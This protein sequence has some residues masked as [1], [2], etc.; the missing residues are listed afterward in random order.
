MAKIR[1]HKTPTEL[2]L[3]LTADITHIYVQTKTVDHMKLCADSTFNNKL[4][5][6]IAKMKHY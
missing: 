2:L 4:D 6:R 1:T 5:C 3:E